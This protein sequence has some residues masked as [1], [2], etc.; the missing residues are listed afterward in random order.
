MSYARQQCVYEDRYGK[1]LSSAGNPTI[2]P[3]ITSI[4]KPVAKLWPFLYIQHGHHPPSWIL[5]NRKIAPFDPP[6]P[7]TLA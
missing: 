6:T 7:K 2:E 4:S 5:S 1:N 3:S